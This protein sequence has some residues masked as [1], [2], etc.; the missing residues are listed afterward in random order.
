MRGVWEGKWGGRGGREGGSRGEKLVYQRDLIMETH[1]KPLRRIFHEVAQE[2]W[3]WAALTHTH[4]CT[5][6]ALPLP[7]PSSHL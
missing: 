7:H 5:H 1:R 3:H 4:I 6:I 2:P